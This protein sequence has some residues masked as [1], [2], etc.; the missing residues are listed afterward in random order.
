MKW[1]YGLRSPNSNVAQN[2]ERFDN[3]PDIIENK[4]GS[5][6]R[7]CYRVVIISNRTFI[8]KIHAFTICLLGGSRGKK[9]GKALR[10]DL[11]R[12]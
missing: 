11:E 3:E 9:A 10:A 12:I 4:I 7:L 2:G 5:F 6:Y 8:Y 1:L